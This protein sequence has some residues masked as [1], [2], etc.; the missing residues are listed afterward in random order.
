MTTDLLKFPKLCSLYY[1]LLVYILENYPEQVGE[2]SKFDSG[3][4][5]F[6]MGLGM[7]KS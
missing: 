5:L 1:N 4:D 3:E 2:G 7:I 6:M